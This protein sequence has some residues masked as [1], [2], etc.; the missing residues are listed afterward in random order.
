MLEALLYLDLIEERE[1]QDIS[2]QLQLHDRQPLPPYVSRKSG[3]TGDETPPG[4]EAEEWS[5]AKASAARYKAFAA[6]QPGFEWAAK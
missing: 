1:H 6:S 5:K 2:L 3:K 4:L